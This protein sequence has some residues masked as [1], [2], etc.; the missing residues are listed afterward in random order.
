MLDTV[1]KKVYD[2][3]SEGILDYEYACGNNENTSL[4]LSHEINNKNI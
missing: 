4:R 1:L 2:L 3:V